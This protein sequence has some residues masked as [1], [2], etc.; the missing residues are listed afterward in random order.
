MWEEPN[1]EVW[2]KPY[3]MMEE[4]LGLGEGGTWGPVEVGCCAR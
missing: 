2:D 1:C 4:P 3:L